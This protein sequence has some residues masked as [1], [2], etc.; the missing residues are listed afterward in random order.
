MTGTFHVQEENLK[1]FYTCLK[2]IFQNFRRFGTYL[3]NMA[4]STVTGTLHH[5]P[6]EYPRL[7]E[8]G[9]PQVIISSIKVNPQSFVD[10]FTT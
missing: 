10:P 4:S 8:V 9:L 2:C 6:L 1:V 3:Y 5:N 7:K